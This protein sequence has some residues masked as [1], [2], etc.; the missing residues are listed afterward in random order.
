MFRCVYL[1]IV[2]VLTHK[3]N[4][5]SLKQTDLPHRWAAAVVSDSEH[6]L[7]LTRRLIYLEAQG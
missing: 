5:R 3:G 7:V 1:N 6:G 2:V 4:I